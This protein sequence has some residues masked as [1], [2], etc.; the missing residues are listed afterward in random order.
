MYIS[1]PHL[2]EEPQ[3][4]TSEHVYFTP[5]VRINRGSLVTD[6]CHLAKLE[7]FLYNLRCST[8][9][10]KEREREINET[11]LE[12]SITV[13]SGLYGKLSWLLS[14]LCVHFLSNFVK[15]K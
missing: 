1:S 7:G 14:V 3:T 2:G 10:Q 11:N 15:T 13:A 4:R 6:F 5:R 12:R 9:P 8:V